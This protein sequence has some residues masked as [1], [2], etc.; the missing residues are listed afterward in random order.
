[1]L[2]AALIALGTAALCGGDLPPA[3]EVMKKVIERAKQDSAQRYDS[4]YVYVVRRVTQDLDERGSIKKREQFLYR[5]VIIDGAPYDRL[6]EKNG[7]PLNEEERKREQERE[8]KFRHTLAE[9]KRKKAKGEE[10]EFTV[11]E[12][13]VNKF[14][15]E[16][17]GREPIDG[18]PALVAKFEP[19]SRNLPTKRRVDFLINK[20]A[21][22]VWIDEQDYEVV[23][24]QFH[25]VEP[26]TMFFGLLASLRKLEGSVEQTRVEDH[27]W[28]PAR[29]EEYMEG[30][31]AFKA[32]HQRMEEQFSDFRKLGQTSPA[33]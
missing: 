16:I 20:L 17:T 18:R 28:L 21:G 24:A 3:G 15:I 29:I 27:V 7:K 1:M 22:K 31:I 14:K 6:I 33:Q 13:L 12:E 23:R 8:R 32:L 25:L 5:V 19:R 9:K 2:L 4:K 10:D 30:R 26:A 11:D